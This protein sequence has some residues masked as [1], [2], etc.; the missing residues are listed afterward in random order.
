L[1][2]AARRRRSRWRYGPVPGPVAAIMLITTVAINT[3]V[4]RD[5]HFLVNPIA[6]RASR[7]VILNDVLG[8]LRARSWRGHVHQTRGPGHAAD[9]C[10]QIPPHH[11][12]VVVCGGDGTVREV[13]SG[14]AGS[15]LPLAVL[16]AG[17]ENLIARVMGYRAEADFLCRL[18]FS[19]RIQPIDLAE[20]GKRIFLVVAGVGFDAE[21]VARLARH[22]RGHVSYASYV[23]PLLQTW[24]QHRFPTLRVWAEEEQVCAGPGLAFVGNM[25]RYALGLRILDRASWNDGLLDLCVYPCA[26]RSR[27]LR[28]AWNTARRC[29]LAEGGTVYRQCRRVRIS[30]DQPVPVQLDGDAAGNLPID[31]RVLPGRLGLL[32]PATSQIDGDDDK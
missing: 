12:A 6:G 29:H 3:S 9:I 15:E 28:H 32:L 21:V 17:L 5:V 22:R 31:I 1:K 11:R 14:L 20:A 26:S 18:L 19:G 27:L 2:R 10:R 7:R 25:A 30:A 23:L 24:L 8:R 13:A 16:P 4:S